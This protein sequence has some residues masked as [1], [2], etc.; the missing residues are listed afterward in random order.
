MKIF[1]IIFI[2]GLL[3]SCSL[4][5][6]DTKDPNDVCYFHNFKIECEIF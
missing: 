1:L 6:R 3:V 5:T 2:L 4:K